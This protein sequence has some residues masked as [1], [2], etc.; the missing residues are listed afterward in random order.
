MAAAPQ[1]DGAR[2]L[3]ERRGRRAETLAVL[4]LACQ[5]FRIVARRWRGPAGEIDIV[6][7]RGGLLVACEVKARRTEEVE[8]VAPRQ[9][10]RIGAALDAFVAHRPELA[11]C[12]R[13]F[14]LIEVRPGRLPRHSR[15]AWRP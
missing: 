7:R 4:L 15:D 8:P 12:E 13:R 10:R 5:G 1:A 6:A 14:D 9:W 11:A 2:R 3:A